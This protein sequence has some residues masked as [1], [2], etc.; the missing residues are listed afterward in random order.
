M[1]GPREWSAGEVRSFPGSV[2]ILAGFVFDAEAITVNKSDMVPALMQ[3][4]LLIQVRKSLKEN[5]QNTMF[6]L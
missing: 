2:I 6:F 5:K 3:G 4:T 1:M